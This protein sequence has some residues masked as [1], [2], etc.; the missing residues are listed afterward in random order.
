MINTIKKDPLARSAL[1]SE[2]RMMQLRSVIENIGL[3][4]SSL[5]ITDNGYV[6]EVLR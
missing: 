1:T 4:V 3:F 6:I 5:K 2:E